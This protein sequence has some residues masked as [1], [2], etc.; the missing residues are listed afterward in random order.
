MQTYKLVALDIDGTILTS[1]HTVAPETRQAVQAAMAGGVRVTLATGRAFPSALG[2]ARLLGLHGTPL[3]THDGAY[4]ADPVTGEVLHETRVPLA[5]TREAV[6]LLQEAG[7]KIN[8]VHERFLLS[9]QRIRNFSWKWFHPRRW[10]SAVNIWREARD[11]PHVYA[12]DLVRYL[13]QN[14]V[15]PPK[16]YIMGTPARLRA[17]AA[18]LA[19]R[20]GGALVTLPAGAYAMEVTLAGVSK[21]S[22]L[23]VL[24]GALG[25]KS[26]EV[27]GIGDNYNDVEMIRQSGLGVAMGNAPEDVRQ[28]ANVVTRSNDEHGVAYAI[29]RWVLSN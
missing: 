10:T 3:V 8:V 25:I 16:L 13:E 26:E 6:G 28:L 9:N 23:R 5:V 17:G 14:P 11:Y 19:E 18:L 1:R 7:L 24:A 29:E 2:I 27:V 12:P 4:V 20:L 21:A 15:E 22:G